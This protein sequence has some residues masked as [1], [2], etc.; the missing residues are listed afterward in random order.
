MHDLWQTK[1]A[2]H[3]ICPFAVSSRQVEIDRLDGYRIG[4]VV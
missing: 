1:P 2:G 4:L 3:E